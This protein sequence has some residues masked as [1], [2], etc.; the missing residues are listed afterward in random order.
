MTK[1]T[2][3]SLESR[4]VPAYLLAMPTADGAVNL[5]DDSGNI[6]SVKPFEGYNGELRTV[7]ADV[8]GDGASELIV[9]V[10]VGGGPRIKV[11]DGVTTNS[12]FDGFV[13]D[14]NARGGV[15]LAAG[16]IDGDQIAEIV[17]GSGPGSKP[18]VSFWKYGVSSGLQTTGKLN[19][20]ED[21]FLGGVDVAVGNVT[22]NGRASLIVGAGAGGGPRVRVFDAQ[23]KQVTQDFFAFESS[24]RGGVNVGVSD[25]EGDGID[26]IVAGAGDGGGPV[27]SLFD[28]NTS[29]SEGSFFAGD[30][31][32]RNGV[33]FVSGNVD[34]DG[35]DEI[36]TIAS[37]QTRIFDTES[38]R[39]SAAKLELDNFLPS[40]AP[41]DLSTTLSGRSIGTLLSGI[42]NLTGLVSLYISNPPVDPFASRPL[43]VES[44]LRPG[45]ILFTTSSETISA[46][47]RLG[48]W[49]QYSHAAM[50]IGNGQ[51]A[52]A[53]FDVGVTV[54]KL[55][56][57]VSGAIRIGVMRMPNRSTAEM[58][59]I[60]AVARDI[61][62]K[63]IHY[64]FPG[65]SVTAIEKLT[66]AA[67]MK[68]ADAIRHLSSP[69]VSSAIGE[70]LGRGRLYCSQFVREVYER[71]GLPLGV[72][73]LAAP[74]DLIRLTSSGRIEVV[75]RFDLTSVPTST[76]TIGNR[77]LPVE[78]EKILAKLGVDQLLAS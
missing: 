12:I 30:S 68:P 75:G 19:A 42:S 17:V 34:Q 16:D 53:N 36:V 26:E 31:S 50:Y 9:S 22:N 20:F 47:I 3:Q 48:T 63:G 70:W 24:F 39:I 46:A 2:L 72:P 57:L 23:T 18:E 10:G 14:Q 73:A 43:L 33:D 51:I 11:L 61:A 78:I 15:Q 45:D 7:L 52:D 32:E 74:G 69:V 49:S 29:K 77:L 5:T 67:A 59:E 66:V 41:S 25:R 21:N 8:T 28:G 1:L 40:I 38:F 55:S 71:A 60:V 35:Q 64:N 58:N 4:T 6:T 27:V 56:D 62:S 65:I 76:V 44:D 54:R 13:F 37:K